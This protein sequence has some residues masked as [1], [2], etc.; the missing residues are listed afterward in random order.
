MCGRNSKEQLVFS[1]S[2]HAQR[3]RERQTEKREKERE[4][5]RET[6]GKEL[7]LCCTWGKL[8]SFGTHEESNGNKFALICNF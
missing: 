2:E 8:F 5:E 6:V 4:R 1:Q 3:E 7:T